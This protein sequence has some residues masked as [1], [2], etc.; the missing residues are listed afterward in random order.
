ML[1]VVKRLLVGRPLATDEQEHQRLPKRIALAVF[2]SDAISSTAYASEEILFVVA[3]GASSLALGLSTLVPIALAVALLL[4]IVVTSYRQTIF[5]YPSG[6]GSYVVS[7][8]NLGTYPSLV[9]GASLLI[10]Y[11][12]TVAVSISAGV[13]AIISIPAFR[14][15]AHQRVLLGLILIAGITLANLRGVKESG[16]IFAV[17]T[18]VY[19]VIL[20]L[21]V[22]WGLVQVFFGDIGEVEFNPEQFEGAR[23]AGGSLSVFLLLKGFSSGAVA[24]TG[25]EAIS[26]GVPAFKRP[27]SKNAAA[28]MVWM[29][30]ILGTLFFGVSVL[31]SHLKPYPSHEETVFSQLGRAVFG[32]GPLYVILQFATAAIL[33]LAANTAYADFP[34]LSSIIARDGYLPRQ[35]ANRGDRL[36]FSNGIVF[37][38]V[39][40]GGLLV[41]FKGLTNALI[42]LYAVGVFTSFTLSQWGMVRHHRRLREKGWQRGIAIN[43]V[44]AVSTALVL[45]IVA[46]TKFTSGAWVPLLVVPLIIVLFVAIKAHYRRLEDSLRI[47]PEDVRPSP[48]NHTVVVLVGRVHRGVVKA[49]QYARSMRPNHITALYI[50]VDPDDETH[51]L[52]EWERFG[53][54]V[55]L[56]IVSSPYRELT[57]AV[58]RYLEEL[59][60]RWDD[61]TITVVIPE[62]VAG[63]LLSPTQLLHNQSAGALKLTLLY[64]RNTVVTSVPYHVDARRNGA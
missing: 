27:E 13:A 29:G 24:L 19:I 20:S 54:E 57:P 47:E 7:R 28:T 52:K 48:D 22:C 4:T 6:G 45:L 44:G 36:V 39:A 12:L 49:L 56:E 1:E 18:Y 61:D 37:L 60:S 38:A 41:A 15:I 33:T 10:D 55:P 59:D 53:F 64:R 63:R 17:P 43:A 16:R 32:G 50:S 62:F 25:V 58:E 46:G 42:P 35:L 11:I 5:A 14:G 21:L 31:A 30:V 2:S 3:L 34:R 23:Q 40:A 26:N 8:E 51:I 9:A